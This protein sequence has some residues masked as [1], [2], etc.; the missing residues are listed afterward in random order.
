MA[1]DDEQAP[2]IPVVA[3]PGAP[4][5]EPVP[6]EEPKPASPPPTPLPEPPPTPIVQES[7]QPLVQ[8]SAPAAAPV[9]PVAAAPTP[10][11]RQ[12]S[13][14]RM[15]TRVQEKKRARLEK[16]VALA[17]QKRLITNNDVENLLKVS[18]ATATNYLSELV[19]TGRLKRSGAPFHERYEPLGG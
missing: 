10:T 8:E 11:P 18:D 19:K 2:E 17:A 14:A 6:P 9:V 12:S 16:I 5:S 7:E 1:D 15:R 13:G 3:E 4:P